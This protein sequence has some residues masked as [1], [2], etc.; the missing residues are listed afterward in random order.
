MAIA[1]ANLLRPTLLLPGT[2]ARLRPWAAADAPALARHAN[3][4]A[5]WL[6][7]RDR[8]PHPYHLAD[9]EAYLALVT[10]PDA[11]HL[12]LCLEVEGEAAGSVSVLFKQDVNRRGAEVGYWL[13]QTHWGRGLATAAVRVLTAYA[14]AHFDLCRLYAVVYAH[15][16]ASGRVLEKAGYALEGRLR[17]AITK[18]GHTFDA[19]LYARVQPGG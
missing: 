1:P 11:E 8:F 4:R 12:H 2:G 15:N 18:D 6:N 10:G 14:F 9:A 17:Q 7:L 5:I 13:G 3:D 16:P 19:L